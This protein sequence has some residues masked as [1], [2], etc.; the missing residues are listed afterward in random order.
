MFPIYIIG[1]Q[2]SFQASAAKCKWS[3][4]ALRQYGTAWIC[5]TSEWAS[6]LWTTTTTTW[7]HSCIWWMFPI[8]IIGRQG[9]RQ[10]SAANPNRHKFISPPFHST[11]VLSQISLMYTSKNK[12]S[13]PF[14]GRPKRQDGP[15]L[16]NG[17]VIAITYME[18]KKSDSTYSSSAPGYNTS[19]LYQRKLSVPEQ[20][21]PR[22]NNYQC[23]F[24]SCEKNDGDRSISYEKFKYFTSKLPFS[25]VPSEAGWWRRKLLFFFQSQH[26]PP[27]LKSY[28][29]SLR[30]SS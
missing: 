3:I 10:A 29:A 20:Y 14:A 2:G 30:S 4:K 9:S 25:F 1:R 22:C 7:Y 27:A 21:R 8:Y 5:D 26:R 23:R 13:G 12:C 6:E 17:W 19:A 18:E 11:V 28:R 15:G 16:F 24:F